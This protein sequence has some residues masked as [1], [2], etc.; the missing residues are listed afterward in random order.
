MDNDE[1]DDDII[2]LEGVQKTDSNDALFASANLQ[3][4]QG[5]EFTMNTFFYRL[6]DKRELSLH[7]ISDEVSTDSSMD[8]YIPSY[9]SEYGYKVGKTIR[10]I[11]DGTE[12]KFTIKG[13]ISE[14]QYGNYGTDYIGLYLS[15]DA[16]DKICNDENFTQVKEYLIKTSEMPTLRP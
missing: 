5:A 6:D 4:F 1:I 15:D 16:Y 13:I 8:V 2:A 14:M 12:Y 7:K 11:I 9:L 10:Y 3:E